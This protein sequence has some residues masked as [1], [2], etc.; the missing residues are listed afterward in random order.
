MLAARVRWPGAPGE[1]GDLVSRLRAVIVAKEARQARQQSE[2]E[3]SRDRKRGGQPGHHGKGLQRDPEPG[4]RK[5]A[6]P[7]A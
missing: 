2:W 1:Q 6:E 5:T 7:S 3:R 4:E